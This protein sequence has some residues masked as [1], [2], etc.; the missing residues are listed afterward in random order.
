MDFAVGH[1]IL[2][3]IRFRDGAMP[4]YDRTYLVVAVGFD[5]LEVVN[6]SSVK[7]KER[8]LLF[9]SNELIKK[10]K[11]PFMVPSFVKLDSLVRVKLSDCANLQ[12]LHRGQKLDDGEL[13]RIIEKIT[14][15]RDI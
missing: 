11:P 7:G 15:Q 4:A 9:P 14:D 3:R 2:G 8:K 13:K 5:Y 10:Y 1:G 12:I 6:V